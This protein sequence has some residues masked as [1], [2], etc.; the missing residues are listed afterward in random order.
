MLNIYMLILRNP[1]L[2]CM[3]FKGEYLVIKEKNT[4]PTIVGLGYR[5]SGGIRIRGTSLGVPTISEI[6]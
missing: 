1:I 6:P 5:A 3:G 4:E 2:S